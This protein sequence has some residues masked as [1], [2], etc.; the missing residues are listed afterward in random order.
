[1]AYA[2]GSVRKAPHIHLSNTGSGTL[3]LSPIDVGK[4]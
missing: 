4:P 2:M 3:D 1:M